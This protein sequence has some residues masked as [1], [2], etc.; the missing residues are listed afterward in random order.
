PA[1]AALAG[2]LYEFSLTHGY[3]AVSGGLHDEVTACGD[4]YR[5]DRRLW[6]QTEALKAHVARL[7]DAGDD[8]ARNRLEGGIE[9]LF[10]YHLMGPPGGWREHINSDG[11]NFYGSYPASTLYHLAFA[12]GELER[13]NDVR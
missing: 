3:D 11:E 8:A 6:P 10:R 7:Q 2:N 13:I 1:A 4:V 5:D 9:S 12:V